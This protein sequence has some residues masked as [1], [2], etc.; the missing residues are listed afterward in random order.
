MHRYVRGALVALIIFLLG[1]LPFLHFRAVYGHGKRLREVTPG[2][3]YRSGQMTA[4]GFADA[5]RRLGIHA[6][7]NL[8]EDF[9]D[10]DL[11]QSFLDR[12]TVRESDLCRQLGV[13]F[14]SIS[15]D[16]V[17]KRHA[18]GER[19]R[20]I[21]EFLAVMDDRSRRRWQR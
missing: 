9:P 12:H 8:Q 17:A 7:I 18:P 10:P 5:V 2:L 3:V 4:E 13:R 11:D 21:D 1:V 19:P 15:P 20:A 14:V 6:V 16:L